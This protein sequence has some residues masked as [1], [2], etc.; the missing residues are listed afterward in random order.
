MAGSATL[1]KGKAVQPRI[2]VSPAFNKKLQKAITQRVTVA[3]HLDKEEGE[4]IEQAFKKLFELQRRKVAAA[5][6][7]YYESMLHSAAALASNPPFPAVETESPLLPYASQPDLPIH[8]NVKVPLTFP[9]TENLPQR[10]L[11]EKQ[12]KEKGPVKRRTRTVF[13][14]KTQ[15]ILAPRQ[16]A[17]IT[18]A[19]DMKWK[20]LSYD[21]F[22]RK[23]KSTL[24]WQKTGAGATAMMQQY[25]QVKTKAAQ[26]QK[27]G[28]DQFGD[29]AVSPSGLFWR[30]SFVINFPKLTPSLDFIRESFVMSAKRKAAI[31]RH[32]NL[33]Y[34]SKLQG[35]DRFAAA[36]NLRPLLGPFAAKVGEQWAEYV[37]K[38]IY[39][40]GDEREY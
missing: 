25:A 29:F 39:T 34:K 26:Y 1:I 33:T 14:D 11:S 23:P 24:F 13:S 19:A 31:P 36:E 10:V 12:L 30:F 3:T 18:V 20:P 35:V 27:S 8:L 40:A 21:Y 4:S 37:N 2:K 32:P 9:F 15:T 22:E 28:K 6:R 16:G 7:G 38:G 5:A 17:S